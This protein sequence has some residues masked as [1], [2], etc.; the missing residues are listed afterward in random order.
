[1]QVGA[2]RATDL[3][4]LTHDSENLLER[5]GDLCGGR[6]FSSLDKPV[7]ELAEPV[8]KSAKLVNDRSGRLGSRS[9]RDGTEGRFAHV[10]R[11]RSTA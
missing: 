6:Q 3:V 11:W 7:R 9:S 2:G 4:Q 10:P 1:M 5:P 8:A